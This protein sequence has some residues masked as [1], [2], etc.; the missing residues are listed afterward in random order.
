MLIDL[1]HKVFGMGYW[2]ST[3]G[4]SKGSHLTRYYM[5]NRLSKFS[6]SRPPEHRVLSISH[7]ETLGRLLG[8]ADNQI[9]DFAYPDINI[10]RLSFTNDEFDAVV[11]DQV[12]AHV[13]GDPYIAVAE[14]FRVLKP[15]GIAL[16]TTCFVNPVHSDPCDYWRFSPQAL[17]L[18]VREHADI[19]DV[20]GWGNPY[21]MLFFAL[22][23]RYVPIPH[24]RWHIAHYLAT[25]QDHFWPIVTWILAQKRLP[26]PTLPSA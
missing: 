14:T 16:H 12:L 13:Q 9:K 7:S 4:L 2:A 6:Q 23:L 11:S 24:A 20:G 1:I 3:L 26:T 10:L 17:E 8:Y 5:Y 18:L 21:V 25:K 19:I 15:G 22:G